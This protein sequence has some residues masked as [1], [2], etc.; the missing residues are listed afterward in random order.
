M[1]TNEQRTDA[2]IIGGGLAGLSTAIYLAREGKRVRLL[3]QSS[4]LGGRARTRTQD[5][6]YLNMGPHALYRAGRGVEVLAELGVEPRGALPPLSGAFAVERGRKHTFPAGMVSMLTT[7]LF[8]LSAKLEAGRLLASLG[9]VD[10]APWTDRSAAEWV[11]SQIS[12]E[13]VRDFIYAVFRV[14][15]YVN[16]PER[17][18]AATALDQV[19]KALTQGVLYLH[20]GWQSLIDSLAGVASREGVM[21]ETGARV[22]KVLRD[23]AGAVSGVRLAAGREIRTPVVVIASS[24][25]LAAR[26]VEG[27]ERTPLAKWADEAIPVRAA[28]LDIALS[29]LP[30]P[31]STFALGIDRPLYLSVHSAAARL[32]PEGGALIQLAKYLAPGDDE[33]P[34]VAERDL[35]DLMDIIQ[36]GWREALVYR[37]YLPDMIVMND[38]P[39]ARRNGA[40][41]RPGPEVEGVPGL[42]VAGDWVGKEGLLAD[43]SL[44]S[45]REAARSAVAKLAEA[46]FAAAI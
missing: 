39:E 36:P 40:E 44:A 17:L 4:G 6:F 25:A 42:F 30:E 8:G 10:P 43:A 20:G 18:S 38:L 9:K 11:R 33:P 34:E 46:S 1:Q 41:G 7:S 37:R 32:A 21:I 28:C 2:V 14:A 29:R 12:N 15:T 24:P 26:L 45:S 19:K 5:G 13:S 31:R 27:S 3:E 35:E 22:E 23:G 16:D